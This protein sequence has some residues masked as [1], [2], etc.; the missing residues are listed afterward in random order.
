[1]DAQPW[2]LNCQAGTIDLRTGA[3]REHRRD[4]Y[5]TK[6]TPVGWSTDEPTLWLGFL[7]R[8]FAGNRN[9]IEFV[10]RLMGISL[11]GEVQEHILPI[12]FGTGANGKS[13]LIT[14]W[15]GMLGEYATKAPATLLMASKSK[16]HPTEIAN[17]HGRRLVA[18]SETDDGCRLSEALV[19][20]LTGGEILSARRMKE[21][22]WHFKPSHTLVLSTNHK[23]IIR[24]TDNGI[25]RRILFIPFNITIPKEEQDR[26]LA[27]KLRDELPAILHWTVAGCLDWQR[28]GLQPPKDVLAATSM[29]RDDMDVLGQFIDQ[30]C[31][32]APDAEIAAGELYG[33]YKSWAQGRS[34]Y[35]QTQTAFGS[36]LSERGFV[37]DRATRGEHRGRTI[38]HGLALPA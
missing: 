11:V 38:W 20:D 13:V 15:M 14:T 23:P 34:E 27:T 36:R 32:V 22:F 37:N 12:L 25:W 6:C 1:M 26:E 33:R 7:N 8:I 4:D 31:I 3:L 30:C 21:D 35:V 5:L 17:L 19:K 2:L 28:N 16:S 24:G 18:A 10:R 9:L 29:Y